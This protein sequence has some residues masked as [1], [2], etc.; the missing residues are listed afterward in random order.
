VFLS[1]GKVVGDLASPTVDSV[2]GQMKMLG[3]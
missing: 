3:T 1:D 2:L